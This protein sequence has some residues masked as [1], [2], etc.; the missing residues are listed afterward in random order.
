MEETTIQKIKTLVETLSFDYDKF[1][2][3]NKT[4]G[5]RVRKSS[6]ELRELLKNLRGEILEARKN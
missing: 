2:K 3:G 5:T 1:E 6:Q 4:A